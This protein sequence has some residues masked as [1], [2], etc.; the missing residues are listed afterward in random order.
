MTGERTSKIS[1][2]FLCTALAIA[3]VPSCALAGRSRAGASAKADSGKYSH[4]KYGI[5]FNVPRGMSLYTPQN[6]G[7]VASLISA[8]SPFILVN[9]RF[10][11]ENINV[12]VAEN[13]SES[14]LIGFKKMLD[15]T[16]NMPLPEYRRISVK[17]IKIGKQGK[18][19]AVE[20]V[21]IMRG[22]ILGK[23]RQVTFVHRGRGFTFTCATAVGRF[24][25]ANRQFFD[26]LFRSMAFE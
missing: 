17:S 3:V 5:S 11:E 7:P 16:P 23:L 8:G 26:G 10:T 24:D 14:D 25:K 18:E 15:E 1:G 20:H 13:I 21:F 19:R 6:P 2:I 4:K 12:K 22:N 9:P